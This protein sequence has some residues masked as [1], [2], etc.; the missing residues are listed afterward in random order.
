MTMIGENLNFYLN[1]QKYFTCLK[2]GVQYF[3]MRKCENAS[4][5]C[6]PHD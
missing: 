4:I 1:P 3:T 5:S 6:K 2:F